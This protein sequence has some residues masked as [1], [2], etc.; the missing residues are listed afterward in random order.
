[1]SLIPI[2]YYM[3]HSRFLPLP[4][5][6]HSN[7][8][9]SGSYHPPSIYLIIQFQYTRTCIATTKLLTSTPVGNR[10]ISGSTVF[11]GSPFCFTLTDYSFSK[12]L[13]SAH[14]LPPPSSEAV[15]YICNTVRFTCHNLHSFLG[16][17]NLPNDL[18]KFFFIKFDFLCCKVI[19]VFTNA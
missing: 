3:D 5:N 7:S 4:I 17:F 10:F 14:L 11:T 19:W 13:E 6:S 18:L 15:L 16:S 1:M 12:L 2:H 9:K 8:E